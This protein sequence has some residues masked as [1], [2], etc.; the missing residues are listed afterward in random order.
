MIDFKGS[1]FEAGITL[2]CVRRYLAYPLGI[3]LALIGLIVTPA[4]A[5][6]WSLPWVAPGTYTNPLPVDIPRDGIVE[7]CA[8][9]SIILGQQ[10]G[11]P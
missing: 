8:D 10:L 5:E 9:P 3:S 2:V 11:D 1:H 7:S 6:S 4:L